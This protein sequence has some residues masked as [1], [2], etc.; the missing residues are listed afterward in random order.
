MMRRFSQTIHTLSLIAFIAIGALLVSC[1]SDGFEEESPQELPSDSGALDG[2]DGGPIDGE[3]EMFTDELE[4]EESLGDEEEGESDDDD[5]ISNADIVDYSGLRASDAG[6]DVV[7]TDEDLFWELNTFSNE[8]YVIYDDDSAIVKTSNEDIL[9]NIDGAYVTIDMLTYSVSKVKITVSGK[10]SD[11]QLK[12]YG[13]K[14]FM[15]SLNGLDLTCSKGPAIND[16]CKKRAYVHLAEGTS[17]YLKDGS[18]YSTEPFYH[19][20]SSAGSEDRKGCFFSEGNLIFSGY[21]VLSV[22]GKNK[23]GIAT[24]GYLYM[25]PGVTI[26]V[27]NAVK[28]DIHVKG[29]SDDGYGI[30]IAGG[31]IYA[32]TSGT[33]GKCLKTDLDAEIAGGEF[34]LYTTGGSEYDSDEKD[35]S[36]PAGIKTN[37]DI[38]ISGGSILAQ[39][40]G[41]G[42]K[43]LNS[44]G[45]I[46]IY[47]GEIEAQTSGSR[48]QYSSRYTSSP[49]GIKADGDI[50]IYGGT[51]TITA[52][53]RNEGAEGMESKANLTVN[54]GEIIIEAYDDAMNAS[55]SITI[56]GGK[57]YCYSTSNDGIDSNGSL[58]FAGGLIIGSGTDAP[59][60][61][62]DCDS[63]NKYFINGGIVIGT[64]GSAVSPSSSSAQRTV[65]YNGFSGVSGNILC[66]LNSSGTPVLLY[67][68]PRTLNGMS[69][70]FSSPDLVS[71]SYTIT[72]GATISSNSDYWQ[73]WY[74]DGSISGG[75]TLTSFTSSSTVTTVGSSTGGGDMGGGGSTGGTTP[76]GGSTGGGSTG[77]GST[78][79]GGSSGGGPGGF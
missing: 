35:T 69:L 24:D 48:Y 49:K 43:G 41:A 10:S 25:R 36:S 16:Q 37:G 46:T 67:K 71:G 14:K 32:Y 19:S 7:G 64:G 65:V 58:T 3:D 56:N 11:G 21:G 13:E 12:I 73:G 42:G 75:S 31:L 15:L 47:D 55:S 79:G 1:G 63:S 62:L 39:S 68:L 22:T 40:T 61:G 20:T 23:H 76:G 60:E 78:G 30:Y 28:N 74:S 45:K 72:S 33:A 2:P 50:E 9:Y 77:G 52:S 34:Y 27:T 6:L 17:N 51:I 8:V 4:D 29:D 70:I 59:E 5:L 26:D 57:V 18:S 66:I 38:I 53:G 44:D 54:D